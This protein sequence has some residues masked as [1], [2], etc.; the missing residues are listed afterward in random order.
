[1]KKIL[2]LIL[3]SIPVINFGQSNQIL[4]FK[5]QFSPQ[6]NY[7]QT[8]SSSAEYELTYDGSQEFLASLK[9]KDV[10]N[11]TKSKTSFLMESVLKTGKANAD[12]NFPVTIEYLKSL[13][14]NGKTIIPNGTVIYG[15]GSTSSLPQLDSIASKGLDETFKKS[16]FQIVQS[17]FAQ[18]ALPEKKL[19]VGESF[20]QESPLKLP[21]AGLNFDM[22]ITTIYKLKSIVNKNAFFDIDQVYTAKVID[23]NDNNINVTGSGTGKLIYDISN[24]YATE[25]TIDM[26]LMFDFKK[27]DI[28]LKLNSSSSI[29]QEAKITRSK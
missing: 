20:S 6:T 28:S 24:Y 1:M 3:V 4:D 21:I 19:K 16:I 2:L 7:N 10:Q 5:I 14:S 29:K 27:G 15:K 17:S 13:D 12:G 26:K 18:L 9:S 23:Q 11:P 8:M 25:N 22:V